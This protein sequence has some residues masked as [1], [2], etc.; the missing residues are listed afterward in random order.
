[1]K[2]FH[3]LLNLNVTPQFIVCFSSFFKN[4]VFMLN[5]IYDSTTEIMVCSPG[6]FVSLMLNVLLDIATVSRLKTL[7]VRGG[8]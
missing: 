4:P 6:D 2:V 1:M 5:K 3:T 7:R 8:L